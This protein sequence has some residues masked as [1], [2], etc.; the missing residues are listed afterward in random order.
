ML[1]LSLTFS[2][3]PKTISLSQFLSMYPRAAN[4]NVQAR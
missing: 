4:L 1:L 2:L 3:A